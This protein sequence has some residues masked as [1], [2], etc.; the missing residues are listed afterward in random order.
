MSLSLLISNNEMFLRK[1]QNHMDDKSNKR[2]KIKNG[3]IATNNGIELQ[4]RIN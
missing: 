1:C 2:S 3:R 4:R